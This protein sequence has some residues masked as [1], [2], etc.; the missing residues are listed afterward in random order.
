MKLIHLFYTMVLLTGL[1]GCK[2]NKDS[3][4]LDSSLCTGKITVPEI[5]DLRVPHPRLFISLDQFDELKQKIDGDTMLTGWYEEIKKDAGEILSLPPSQHY[6]RDGIRL[7]SVSREVVRRVYTLAFLY[8]MEGDP[9]YLKRV[10]Q[11]LEAVAAFPDW[12]PS[13]FLDV[14]EMCHAFAIGYDWLYQDLTEDQRSLI[15]EALIDKGMKPYINGSDSGKGKWVKNITNWN[16]VCNG[17]VGIAAL[18]IGTEEE[19]IFSKV[20]SHI[21][22]N[23][24]YALE[25]YAPDGA[26][27]EGVGYWR[28]GTQYLTLFMGALQSATGQLYGLPDRPGLAEACYFPIYMSGLGNR[29]YQ[30]GDGRSRRISDPAMFWL[31]EHYNNPVFGVWHY[32]NIAKGGIKPGLFD[33]LWY[34]LD[35]KN[36]SELAKLPPDRYFRHV[37]VVTVRSSF[38]DEN[39][40]MAG[41][42]GRMISELHHND[43]DQ[44]S[45]Y[46]EAL[47]ETW[48]EELG[49]GYY[50]APGY[51]EYRPSGR[52]WNYYPKR[53]EGQNTLVINQ[54]TGADQQSDG[55]SRIITYK[56][57][58]DK[59]F[60]ITD[61]TDAYRDH[62]AKVMRGLC[63]CD[64]RK[65][66]VIQDEIELKNPGEIRWFMHTKAEILV[67]D[68]A[69][70]VILE[71]NGKKLIASI[72][73]NEPASFTVVEA[74]PLSFSPKDEYWN[75]PEGMKKLAIHF[76]NVKL[77]TLKVTFAEAPEGIQ[78][79][80]SDKKIIPLEHWEDK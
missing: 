69:Q 28:Y 14:G 32:M 71:K 17:G 64:D 53:A 9:K 37:E 3:S 46:L 24:P 56:S 49:S 74:Q 57:Q 42:K 5:K 78:K 27:D 29:S 23:L 20:I 16:F 76:E 39:G 6:I 52:R 31:A 61:I 8:R 51:W 35:F 1:S 54:G 15:R 19:E 72:N 43:L 2:S 41:I 80:H 40:F 33:L 66:V 67:E 73:S 77:L 18:A 13:H 48:A 47:G 38:D 7:L 11:E 10:W 21:M 65:T 60:A 34:K 70:Q 44:G 75:P 25:S 79:N 55:Q 26:W 50:N 45:F 36:L 62:A 30:F 63:L 12:N 59:V 68:N 58:A 4:D 22:E